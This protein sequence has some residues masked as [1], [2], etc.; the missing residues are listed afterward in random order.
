MTP[1]QI[2]ARRAA[3]MEVIALR[4]SARAAEARIS[5]DIALEAVPAAFSDEGA[6]RLAA[7]ARFRGRLGARLIRLSGAGAPPWS[8]SPGASAILDM[9][10][11]QIEALSLEAGAAM[12]A[13]AILGLLKSEE[14]R[15][16]VEALGR[17]PAP[18]ARRHGFT[19]SD[20]ADLAWPHADDDPPERLTP[21]EIA[22]A[23]RRSGAQAFAAW[24]AGQPRAVAARVELLTPPS[25]AAPSESPEAA[26]QGA[27]LVER[28]AAAALAPTR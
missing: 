24:L 5:P 27:A 7:A 22:E 3:A 25:D 23:V 15:R 28:I 20:G 18:A 12:Q 17:D 21:E 14:Q 1:Q 2:E 16:L 8:A 6:R 19:E 10:A 26:R 4:R 9:R 11:E 13:S